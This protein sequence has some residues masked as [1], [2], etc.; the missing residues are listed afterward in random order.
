MAAVGSKHSAGAGPALS[1]IN[2]GDEH[3]S[4]MDVLCA[5]SA[6]LDEEELWAVC[7]ECCLAIRTLS[8]ASETFQTYCVTPDTL[9]FDMHGAVCLLDFEVDDLLCKPPEF[10]LVGNSYKGHVYSLGTTMLMAAHYNM[11]G[12]KPRHSR[13]L[14]QLLAV[15]TD[16]DYDCRADLEL[17]LHEC[18]A[19]I[20]SRSSRD[21]CRALVAS[22]VCCR[23]RDEAAASTPLAKHQIT[24]TPGACS[25]AASSAC[26][27]P[28]EVTH[29]QP[30]S[31]AVEWHPSTSEVV[32]DANAI[33]HPLGAFARGDVGSQQRGAV[34]DRSQGT[35]P[36]TRS[37]LQGFPAARKE[38]TPSNSNSISKSTGDLSVQRSSGQLAAEAAQALRATVASLWASTESVTS[39]PKRPS[40]FTPRQEMTMTSAFSPF[41]QPAKGDISVR[42]YGHSEAT[43]SSAPAEQKLKVHSLP[44]AFGSS[45]T[46]FTPIVLK[47][48]RKLFEHGAEVKDREAAKKIKEL[49][50]NLLRNLH[51]AS[52]LEPT[53]PRSASTAAD[54]Y[55]DGAHSRPDADQLEVPIAANDANGPYAPHPARANMQLLAPPAEYGDRDAGVACPTVRFRSLNSVAADPAL[56]EPSGNAVG[57]AVVTWTPLGQAK[58]LTSSPARPMAIASE[59]LFMSGGAVHQ[60]DEA[61]PVRYVGAAEGREEQIPDTSANVDDCIRQ[62]KVSVQPANNE[63]KNANANG[64]IGLHRR[65]EGDGSGDAI[66][67]AK[68]DAS[69][70]H[71]TD[72][73]VEKPIRPRKRRITKH[74]HNTPAA[75]ELSPREKRDGTEGSILDESV[76]SAEASMRRQSPLGGAASAVKDSS[77]VCAM[78]DAVAPALLNDITSPTPPPSPSLSKDSGV[79]GLGHVSGDPVLM[80]RLLASDGLRTR[81][82]LGRVLCLL[83]DEF[84]YDGYMDN[85]VEDLAM[86]EY[87]ASLGG[88]R[89]GTFVSAVSEKYCDLYWQDELLIRLYEAINGKAPAI[90]RRPVA[91]VSTAHVLRVDEPKAVAEQGGAASSA[92]GHS[93]QSPFRPISSALAYG[94]SGG[95]ALTR[96]SPKSNEDTQNVARSPVLTAAGAAES[97]SV[98]AHGPTAAA[99]ADLPRSHSAT[100]RRSAL[101]LQLSRKRSASVQELDVP[102]DAATPLVTNSSLSKSAGRVVLN[103]GSTE[104]Q[105]TA[106]QLTLVS[107][108]PQPRGSRCGSS[109]SSGSSSSMSVIR[110]R[111]Q[112]PEL[113][114]EPNRQQTPTRKQRQTISGR[115]ASC[116]PASGRMSAPSAHSG[117]LSVNGALMVSATSADIERNF[118]GMMYANGAAIRHNHNGGISTPQ[119]NLRSQSRCG[120]MPQDADKDTEN[121][122]AIRVIDVLYYAVSLQHMNSESLQASSKLAESTDKLDLCRQLAGAEQQ[123]VMQTKQ[124]NKALKYC[125]QLLAMAD[126]GM[127][128]RKQKA[129]DR[130][131]VFERAIGDVVEASDKLL[132][133]TN[134][135]MHLEMLLA[136]QS[137][138]D[139]GVAC[140]LATADRSRPLVLPESYGEADAAILL[141]HESRET[142]NHRL[143]RLERDRATATSLHAGTPLGLS[144]LLYARNSIVDQYIHHFFI[145]YRYFIAPY[146]LLDFITEKYIASFQ[147]L[148]RTAEINDNIR[149]N[150]VSSD[151]EVADKIQNR[152]LDLL[153]VW[154]EGFYSVDFKHDRRLVSTLLGFYRNQVLLHHPSRADAATR[155]MQDYELGLGCDLGAGSSVHIK[156]DTTLLRA[157]VEYGAT[158]PKKMLAKVTV[159]AGK[160]N[161]R[162]VI[163]PRGLLRLDRPVS[164]V[165][166]PHESAATNSIS[167]DSFSL[168]DYSVQTLV[169]QLTLIEQTYFERCHPVYFMNS[170]AQGIGVSLAV[171]G[172][173]TGSRDETTLSANGIQLDS[174]G[175]NSSLFVGSYTQDAIIHYMMDHAQSISHW[176]AAELV[177]CCGTKAQLALLKKFICIARFCREIRNYATCVAVL[178]GLDNII[179]RQL[180]VWRDVSYKSMEQLNT[181]K[182]FLMSDPMCLSKDADSTRT[183]SSAALTLPTIPSMLIF[184]VHVQQGELGSFTLANGMLKWSKLRFLSKVV[185]QIRVFQQKRYE[186]EVDVALCERLEARIREMRT[187]NLN[188][189]ATAHDINFQR[190]RSTAKWMR[191]LGKQSA[192]R[193]P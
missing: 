30:H 61:A 153:Q 121:C 64:L 150:G 175:G 52:A 11:E 5:R 143:Q 54:H 41:R 86:A 18:D 95:A 104:Q 165:R 38:T 125:H 7:R 9:A 33:A 110:I 160:E 16:Q 181:V 142:A 106:R 148:R 79:G 158:V 161:L 130:K 56:V 57:D 24:P 172:A 85:G 27:V 141:Y 170:K 192:R 169:E 22:V 32:T 81:A 10:Y 168:D 68:R 167:M 43:S 8:A 99:A 109:C 176:V 75:E 155:L 3:V 14:T 149:N 137:G 73:M 134:T 138:L 20:R 124:R 100:D 21:L 135:K 6:W 108:S 46:H 120:A 12:G 67:T 182:M 48:E 29:N 139:V 91:V 180:P 31:V 105:H 102:S 129:F 131:A 39:Q 77:V 40:A 80:E 173:V 152:S 146:Q 145:C 128:V 97:R 70:P 71:S 45:A 147:P 89:W 193:E 119:L 177:N 154:I 164:V 127:E 191:Q 87:V 162:Y 88:L 90:A 166:P 174:S 186:F 144:S 17:V 63:S 34:A 28:T 47:S 107:A 78:Q 136:E 19:H 62:Q 179:V 65:P 140:S 94:G 116:V 123:I 115:I 156:D 112:R 83:R 126:G 15:M 190:P 184:I 44:A 151:A 98:V 2:E 36:I 159:T 133:L 59:I 66:A 187:R 42:V 84:S 51:P 101:Q 53:P 96:W 114:S 4:L 111:G 37:K 185:D 69:Q 113:D 72:C 82:A 26:R 35:D 171:P 58:G 183:T 188:V 157:A 49:K 189:L 76:K 60:V 122:G 74:S 92:P 132:L 103:H 25:P 178:E 93:V 55:G 117:R 163:G 13:R 50:K 23:A 1:S 118:Q